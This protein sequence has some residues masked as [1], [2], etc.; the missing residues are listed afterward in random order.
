[1]K[2]AT[3][4][5]G[6]GDARRSRRRRTREVDPKEWSIRRRAFFQRNIRF[7]AAAK[8][9][10]CAM[11]VTQAEVAKAFGVTSQAVCCWESGKY[12]WRGGREELDQ[13][14]RV[15]QQIAKR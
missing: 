12:A 14:L 5:M 1:M 13:Y 11:D 15:I 9:T 8:A 6:L 10:R 7:S 3:A 2:T 4:N